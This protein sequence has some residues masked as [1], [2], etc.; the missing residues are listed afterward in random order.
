MVVFFCLHFFF[1]IFSLSLI[2]ALHVLSYDGVCGNFHWHF[3]LA[4][5]LAKNRG[6]FLTTTSVDLPCRTT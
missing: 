5:E 1:I 4:S 3:F 2:T 6:F